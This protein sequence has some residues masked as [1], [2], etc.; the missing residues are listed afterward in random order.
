ME[1]PQLERLLER[2]ARA[3]RHHYDAL[4]IMDDET[5]NRQAAILARLAAGILAE[6]EAGEARLVRLANNSDPVI[7][8]MAAVFLLPKEPE[9][10]LA[11]LRRVE[12]E[13][14]LLGFRARCAIERWERGEWG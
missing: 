13:S 10:A 7:A 9:Q 2:F 8:G 14:G 4:E 11:V 3:A 1:V 12:Q 5:A 6:G